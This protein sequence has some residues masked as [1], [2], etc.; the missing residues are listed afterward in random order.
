M[1][2]V[3]K[4]TRKYQITLP[5]A[6]RESVPGLEEGRKVQIEARADEVVIRP[7]VEIPQS[8]AWFWTPEWQKAEQEVQKDVATGN[9][10]PSFRSVKEGLTYL[11]RRRR[12]IKK[13]QKGKS[14]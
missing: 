3:V 9:L 7:I 8:Q 14:T 12:Q 2:Q 13:Q 10:S 11:H 4:I 1:A 5:R 6:I